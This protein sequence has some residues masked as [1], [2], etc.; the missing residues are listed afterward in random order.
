M[1]P[2]E[3]H[4]QVRADAI[5]DGFC[6]SCRINLARPNRRTC[7]PCIDARRTVGMSAEAYER[8]RTAAEARGVS[9]MALLE[10]LIEEAVNGRWTPSVARAS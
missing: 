6:S 9:M 10:W 7:Q 1:K 5:R 3:Y 2:P 8:M 4:R